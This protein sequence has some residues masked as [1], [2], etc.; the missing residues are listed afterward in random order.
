MP[1]SVSSTP[2]TAFTW[3]AELRGE[4]GWEQQQ[5]AHY[6]LANYLYVVA[7]NYLR[8]RQQLQLPL[9]LTTYAP[10]ELAAF[11]QDFTQETLLKLAE[12]NYA[13]LNQFSG[14]GNFTSWV[15]R[16]LKNLIASELRH[17]AW[18]KQ[19]RQSETEQRPTSLTPE[20]I[21][22][23]AQISTILQ[24]CLDQL[25][26]RR[27][28]AFEQCIAEDKRA[29]EVAPL[30]HTTENGVN[31]LVFRARRQLRHCLEQHEIGPETLALFEINAQGAA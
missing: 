28:F 30:L 4:K 3:V 27:R 31:Q 8:H 5:A 29:Q 7:Y 11:A 16:I 17:A 2:R 22:Q 24:H 9:R 20:A 18:R 23:V 14:T 6:D 25:D 10:E 21:A 15:A 1:R 13:R 26:Q 12:K 19:E